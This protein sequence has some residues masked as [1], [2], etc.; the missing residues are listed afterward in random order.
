[1]NAE[2]GDAISARQL[3]VC[4]SR[5]AAVSLRAIGQSQMQASLNDG[6]PRGG[7]GCPR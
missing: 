6:P 7:H 5:V 2:I 1:M 3:G 4:A